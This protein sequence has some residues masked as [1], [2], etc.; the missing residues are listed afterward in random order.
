LI[1]RALLRARQDRSDQRVAT[2]YRLRYHSVAIEALARSRE[3][4]WQTAAS[5]MP[6]ATE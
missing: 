5:Y 3:T 2:F 4:S 1:V 6:G